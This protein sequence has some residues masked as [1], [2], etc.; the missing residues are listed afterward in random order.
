MS[1]IPRVL[2]VTLA[3]V[4]TLWGA[5]MAPPAAAAVRMTRD[6][7]AAGVSS[8][9]AGYAVTSTVSSYA[10]V[11]GTWVQPKATCVRGTASYSAFWVGLGGFTAASQALE[12]IGTTADCSSTGKATYSVWYELVP[13][14]SIPVKLKLAAG[15]TMSAVV[16]VN[17]SS[18]TLR[19]S[20]LT[21]HTVF[22]KRLSMTAPDV[23]SAEWVAEAPSACNA[24]GRCQ[25]LPLAN[26]GTV[27]FSQAAAAT[28]DGV[29]GT[30]SSPAWTAT[31]IELVTNSAAGIGA[32]PG[33]LAPSGGFSVS[34]RS[35]A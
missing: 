17:G 8:N 25:V 32:I 30:I 5:G 33:P 4:V 10:V 20:N 34:W 24:A 23:S 28:V 9:W 3:A 11:S 7:G 2:L 6:A 29:S 16:V 14:P 27:T 1:S 22:T 26:F 18:V 19:I 35:A 31:P 13:A 15:S 21:R 12:Q